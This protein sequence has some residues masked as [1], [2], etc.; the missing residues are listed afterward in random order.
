MNRPA[1]AFLVSL[2]ASLGVLAMP[3]AAAPPPPTG[4]LGGTWGAFQA[5][6]TLTDSGG[7][8]ETECS[9]IELQAPTPAAADGRFTML[10]EVEAFQPGPNRDPDSP[11]KRTKARFEGRVEGNALQLTMYGASNAAP[12]QFSLK[13]NLKTKLIR[14]Y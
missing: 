12:Q 14:C 4:G 2:L 3:T 11:P 1:S 8:L 5:Q 9:S 10:G 7:R 13:R 6:L